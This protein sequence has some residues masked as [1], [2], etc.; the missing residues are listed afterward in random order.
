MVEGAKVLC[1]VFLMRTLKPFMRAHELKASQSPPPPNTIIFR[2]LGFQHMN[3]GGLKRSDRS[4]YP[5]PVVGTTS[6]QG[7]HS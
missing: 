2:G 7:G 1:G 3:L 6:A 4:S 5:V